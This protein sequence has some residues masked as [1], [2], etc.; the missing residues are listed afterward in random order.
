VQ[1]VFK[2]PLEG[3]D[4]YIE[5][6]PN[7]VPLHALAQAL[8][9]S[10]SA[11]ALLAARSGAAAADGKAQA[12]A[13]KRTFKAPPSAASA[14]DSK[15]AAAALS[16]LVG[17]DPIGR[18]MAALRASP[19]WPLLDDVRFDPFGGLL[20]A[21]RWR[22]RSKQHSSGIVP[23]GQ[24]APFAVGAAQYA[25]PVL[26]RHPAA[27]QAPRGRAS[28]AADPLFVGLSRRTRLVKWW[29]CARIWLNSRMICS[30]SAA[31]SFAAFIRHS[32]SI[33][34]PSRAPLRRRTTTRQQQQPVRRMTMQRPRPPQRIQMSRCQMCSR[35]RSYESHHLHCLTPHRTQCTPTPINSSVSRSARNRSKVVHLSRS[36][37]RRAQ[38]TA[39]CSAVYRRMTGLITLPE[40]ASAAAAFRLVRPVT[41]Q[42][43]ESGRCVR[44]SVRP[45]TVTALVDVCVYRHRK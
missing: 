13:K 38:R 10:P 20:I 40:C 1:T 12:K 30:G 28:S 23:A 15:E 24:T 18:F 8:V 33:R 27:A 31:D 43:R 2:T 42:Q 44:G 7:A 29:V 37:V 3:F 16:P 45:M 34:R 4:A 6:N 35:K 5:L 32:N 22:R 14:A 9:L 19:L 39:Q 17:F 26:V 36:F 25:T 21:V 41:Q 11:A